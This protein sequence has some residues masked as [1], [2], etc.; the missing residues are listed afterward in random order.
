MLAQHIPEMADARNNGHEGSQGIAVQH[1]RAAWRGAGRYGLL[2]GLCHAHRSAR[3]HRAAAGDRR[4]RR[5]GEPR[6][7]ALH[8]RGRGYR[9]HGPPGDGAGRR[10]GLGGVRRS[11]RGADRP[12]FRKCR[13]CRSSMRPNGRT[14]RPGWPRRL[15]FPRRRWRQRSPKRMPPAARAAADRFGRVWGE[16][17]PPQGTTGRVQG[18]RRD[19]SHPGRLADRRPCAGAAAGRHAAAQSVCR[20]RRG[21]QCFGAVVL[22]L[23]ARD[24]PVHGGY[25][26]AAGGRSCG[27]AEQAL[28]PTVG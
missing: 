2:S 12:I 21:A 28:H 6:G 3:H 20:R 15:A 22:G 27:S 24:G 7:R 25:A 1:R 8:Q 17:Q 26:G 19:L 18:R 13:R 9:R 10:A 5:A 23:S 4:R 14:A 16:E 11:D